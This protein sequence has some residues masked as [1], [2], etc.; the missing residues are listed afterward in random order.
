RRSPFV[1]LTERGIW[2][3]PL[4]STTAQRV[5]TTAKLSPEGQ[6]AKRRS[7]KPR[8]RLHGEAARRARLRRGRVNP[9]TTPALSPESFCTPDGAGGARRKAPRHKTRQRFAWRSRPEG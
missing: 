4:G 3:D 7:D 5:D 6:G 9:P 8:Q 2:F 1:R